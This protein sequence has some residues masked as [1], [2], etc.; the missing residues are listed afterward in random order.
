[1]RD[2][3]VREQIL[4][5]EAQIERL[6]EVIESCRKVILISKAFTAVG[7]ILMLAMTIGIVRFEPMIMI[8]AL[9]AVIGGELLFFFQTGPAHARPA[10][11]QNPQG[12]RDP[13]TCQKYSFRGESHNSG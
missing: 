3:D 4:A 9:T 8:G 12:P 11:P 5:L 2:G 10:P 6:V 13:T 7:G 1:M